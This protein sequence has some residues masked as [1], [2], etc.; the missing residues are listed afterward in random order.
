MTQSPKKRVS[1]VLSIAAPPASVNGHDRRA[2]IAE[3]AYLRA[4]RRNFCPGYELDDWLAAE[5]EMDS[6]QPQPGASPCV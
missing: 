4:E 2:M 6:M 5:R 1:P 3:A